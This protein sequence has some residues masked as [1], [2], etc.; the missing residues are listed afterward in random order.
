MKK[1]A[2]QAQAYELEESYRIEQAFDINN[3][4]NLDIP[5]SKL[6]SIMEDEEEKTNFQKII[7]DVSEFNIIKDQIVN[8]KQSQ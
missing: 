4:D 5:E 2:E 3:R 6:K 7:D 8:S 1:L